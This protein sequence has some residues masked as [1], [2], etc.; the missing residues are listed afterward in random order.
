MNY[1]AAS[2]QVAID[3]PPPHSLINVCTSDLLHENG[4]KK[5]LRLLGANC[6][7]WRFALPPH[8][9]W[10]PTEFH[11]RAQTITHRITQGGT[12]LSSSGESARLIFLSLPEIISLFLSH[13]NTMIF[14][15]RLLRTRL[16]EV[17]MWGNKGKKWSAKKESHQCCKQS[18]KL[19][20]GFWEE[21]FQS[22]WESEIEHDVLHLYVKRKKS[23]EEDRIRLRHVSVC[24][25]RVHMGFIH[26]AVLIFPDRLIRP[27]EMIE[28]QERIRK[29]E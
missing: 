28:K 9:P 20:W 23:K 15:V 25:S 21:M 14:L 12:H 11:N 17:K 27:W 29:L 7:W 6:H 13:K 18:R 10:L 3:P 24:R 1:T 4:L 2:Q 19:R 16:Q 26:I 8:P 5:Q 22:L